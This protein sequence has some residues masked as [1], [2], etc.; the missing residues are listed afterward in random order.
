MFAG[1]DLQR[2]GCAVHGFSAADCSQVFQ[3]R[4]S[5][6]TAEE[7]Q[8]IGDVA[9][10]LF[11]LD[12]GELVRAALIRVLGDGQPPLRDV[13][14]VLCPCGRPPFAAFGFRRAKLSAT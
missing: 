6:P 1:R 12:S 2:F 9:G 14:V 11:W 13:A 7:L 5:T 4:E 8:Q 3:R 10:L